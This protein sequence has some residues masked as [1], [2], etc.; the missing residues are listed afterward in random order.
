MTISTINPA[1]GRTLAAY[2]GH[3]DVQIERLLERAHLAAETWGR[4]P[5]VR[6]LETLTG[7]ARVLRSRKAELAELVTSEMGKPRHEAAAELEKSAATADFYVS[8]AA[9][10]LGDTRVDVEGVDAWVAREPVGLVLAVMPWNFPFWQ[11]LRFAVPAVA[12]GNGVLLKHSPNVSGSALALEEVFEQAGLPVG[13]FTTLL[14][15]EPRVPD[16]CERLVADDRVAAV[17]LT[18]SNR[19]GSAVGAA[20]GRA[21]KRSV[22]ELGGSDAF[23][24]L[25]D[26]DVEAAAATAVRARFMNAG[27]SCVCAKRFIVEAP[28]AEQFTAALVAGAAGL[29][30]G[31]PTDE[32]TEMGPIAREDLREG[33]RSQ[34]ERS[35]AVGAVLLTGGHE[36]PGDGFFFEPTVLSVPGGPGVPAFDEETFGPVATITVAADEDEAVRFANAT[37]FGLGLSVWT[38]DTARG[39]AFARRVVSG[40]AFI[41]AMVVSDAR[42]PFGGTKCSGYGRELSV[43][44]MLEFVN[45][46][47]YWC[48]T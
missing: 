7:L 26:A 34:V 46:R 13:V 16:V 31:D 2:D 32:K 47:T 43:E 15:E 19:A 28:A 45:T 39:T 37:K 41:N 18:G 11:A 35:V 25:A 17:T 40:A 10:I 23:V 6:R 3:D 42:L 5:L 24:V 38:R 20:A 4:Q 44:G 12:A 21:V 48:G 29:V 22:L 36:L 33:I 27:Q 14:V 1:T 8:R 30:V 9:E